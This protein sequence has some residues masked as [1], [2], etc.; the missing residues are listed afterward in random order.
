MPLIHRIHPELLRFN[1]ALAIRWYGLSYLAAFVFGYLL[2]RRLSR[3]GLLRMTPIQIQDFLGGLCLFGVMLGGRLGY[4]LFYEPSTLLRNPLQFLKVWEGGMASHGG[5]IGSLL[6]VLWYARKQNL[7]PWH[8]GDNL[9]SVV[10]LG[11]GLGRLANFINGELWGRP[12]TVP[13]GVVFPLERPEFQPDG[14]LAAHR[15]DLDF[16][17]LSVERGWLFPRHPSQL[18]Q[19]FAE[20][21]LLFGLLWFLRHRR[22]S[23]VKSGRLCILFF[24]GYGL[25]RF[26]MEFFR[27]PDAK[28]YFGWMSTGQLL[29]L[30]VFAIAALCTRWPRPSD[31][32]GVDGL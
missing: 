20:G 15:Y 27:E 4:F 30:G 29:T 13:W 25:A 10:P 19:A 8:L 5:I 3:Q 24:L 32:G 12:T 14:A 11:L 18:Y 21:F 28:V 6:Y 16:L 1:D 2:L 22:W 17:R 9:V 26:S 31:L 23:R 7:N